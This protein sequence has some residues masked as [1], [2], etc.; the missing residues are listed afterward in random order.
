LQAPLE[1]LV[2]TTVRRALLSHTMMH[3]VKVKEK[4]GFRQ[5]SFIQSPLGVLDVDTRSFVLEECDGGSAGTTPLV[6]L[7]PHAEDF[8]EPVDETAILHRA[9]VESLNHGHG[10]ANEASLLCLV[11]SASRSLRRM[12]AHKNRASRP[13]PL[14]ILLPRDYP[15]FTLWV[16]LCGAQ[17]LMEDENLCGAKRVMEDEANLKHFR[18]LI[19]NIVLRASPSGMCGAVKTND[20]CEASSDRAQVSS[21][22][23][24][25]VKFGDAVDAKKLILHEPETIETTKVFVNA[26]GFVNWRSLDVSSEQTAGGLTVEQA[27]LF[28]GA[29]GLQRQTTC[30]EP[31]GGDNH[32][33]VDEISQAVDEWVVQLTGKRSAYLKDLLGSP[34]PA[35]ALDLA[36]RCSAFEES[37][38][39][40]LI[41]YFESQTFERPT[42]S[43]QVI[44]SIM[45]PDIG[46]Q[47]PESVSYC[48]GAADIR[49]VLLSVSGS[50][51][52]S[53]LLQ[54]E[55]RDFM[56]AIRELLVRGYLEIIP[57]SSSNFIVLPALPAVGNESFVLSVDKS[58]PNFVL[59]IPP[60]VAAA[61][62]RLMSDD[63]GEFAQYIRLRVE[64]T[65]HAKDFAKL[66]V[67]S[68]LLLTDYNAHC[69]TSKQVES[70]RAELTDRE[71]NIVDFELQRGEN[72]LLLQCSVI[73]SR[74][75]H[76]LQDRQ[77]LMKARSERY[78]VDVIEE[79]VEARITS[80]IIAKIAART[81]EYDQARHDHTGLPSR[82][83]AVPQFLNRIWSHVRK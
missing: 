79:V 8:E 53:R 78:H 1:E 23:E 69:E 45:L 61:I 24:D 34:P 17:R 54:S 9:V 36:R 42:T 19:K 50:S 28:V 57:A 12:L 39:Q 59:S 75:K 6:I 31:A 49:D 52:D 65:F 40:D 22:V 26:S 71:Q 14:A 63:S 68:K 18:E 41:H 67:D 25:D 62:Q 47:G 10:D 33:A 80:E 73:A 4:V 16:N 5:L 76:L 13:A 30:Y 46:E 81:K 77:A 35:T 32:A 56:S 72:T 38:T 11:I 43:W 60:P 83:S 51:E 2:R 55:V 44:S 20:T 27:L 82:N 7:Q 66:V 37:F 74:R 58:A 64:W 29:A 15:P 48:R 21:P 3:R 70:I